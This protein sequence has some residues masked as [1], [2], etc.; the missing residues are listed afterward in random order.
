VSAAASGPG[1]RA[2]GELML[3]SRAGRR[4]WLVGEGSTLA[5][6]ERRL[7]MCR[8]RRLVRARRRVLCCG[9]C[10]LSCCWR[11]R[12]GVGGGG[13]PCGRVTPREMRGGGCGRSRGAWVVLGE[14]HSGVHREMVKD[15]GA[16]GIWLV[17]MFW[18]C[19]MVGST[20]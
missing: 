17:E 5:V 15:V 12:N 20:H 10:G 1:L 13:L 16:L 18:C 7:E 4:M 8:M 19:R 6:G 3:G 14:A 9:G 11:L 2:S